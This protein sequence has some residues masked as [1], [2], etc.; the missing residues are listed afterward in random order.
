M[1]PPLQPWANWTEYLSFQHGVHA[2]L[3]SSRGASLCG[4]NG[5]SRVS[6]N[7][8][9]KFLHVLRRIQEISSSSE[10]DRSSCRHSVD[11]E[12]VSSSTHEVSA[13]VFPRVPS[14]VPVSEGCTPEGSTK[15]PQGHL[16]W[17]LM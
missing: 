14:L 2:A 5:V 9:F 7:V 4:T 10:L 17:G 13:C 3:P 1:P 6:R 8:F 15:I 16:P 11:N 12:V